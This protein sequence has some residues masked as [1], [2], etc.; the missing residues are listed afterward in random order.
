M[1][2]KIRIFSTY[3][4]NISHFQPVYSYPSLQGERAAGYHFQS[5]HFSWISKYVKITSLKIVVVQYHMKILD[6]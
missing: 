5:K 6:N 1:L 3:W 4:S 2:E